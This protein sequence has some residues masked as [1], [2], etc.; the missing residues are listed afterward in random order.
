MT[1][2]EYSVPEKYFGYTLTV[3][4][5]YGQKDA[6]HLG[7]DVLNS[8][9]KTWYYWPYALLL[10]TMQIGLIITAFGLAGTNPIPV[11]AILGITIY[12]AKYANMADVEYIIDRH[13]SD[14]GYSGIV[15]K[16]EKND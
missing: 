8:L 15:I 3:S 2:I 5:D 10:F 11:I 14:C 16:W 4:A 9:S 7:N 1:Q 12:M 13:L 6:Y